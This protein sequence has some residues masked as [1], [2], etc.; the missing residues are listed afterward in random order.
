M[1]WCQLKSDYFV[2]GLIVVVTKLSKFPLLCS[3]TPRKKN[4]QNKNELA[5]DLPV[6]KSPQ[7]YLISFMMSIVFKNIGSISAFKTI[8]IT[9]Q[10]RCLFERLI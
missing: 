7:R 1:F 5:K 8:V 9:L 6:I 2:N 4:K 10:M 3:K